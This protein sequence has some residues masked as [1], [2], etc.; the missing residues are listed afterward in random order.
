MKRLLSL[1]P[2]LFLCKIGFSYQTVYSPFTGKLDYVGVSSGALPSGSTQY[3]QNTST[4][5]SGA[6]FYVSSGTVKGSFTVAASTNPQTL[7]FYH[8]TLPINS[9]FG[10]QVVDTAIFNNHIDDGG[11]AGRLVISASTQPFN[12]SYGAYNGVNITL[13]SAE[14]SDVG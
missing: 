1:I 8:T 6:T 7:S 11:V 2:F 4:L 14:G 13:T 5:Q 10:P 12:A 3:I 9:G